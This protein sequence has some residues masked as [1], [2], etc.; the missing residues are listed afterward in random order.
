MNTTRP[1]LDTVMASRIRSARRS[2]SDTHG[3]RLSQQ[4]LADRV[5]VHVITVSQWERAKSTPTVENLAAI[6][7]ETQKPL[8]F[9]MGDGDD[10]EE[11]HRA[12]RELAVTL[13]QRD[14]LDIASTLLDR[15]RLMKARREAEA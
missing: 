3:R 5:G 6:A 2:I 14:Q 8:S 7:R 9:F 12:L 11:D 1:T 15:V 13:V 10:D 4:G